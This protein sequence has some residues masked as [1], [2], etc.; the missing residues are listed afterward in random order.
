MVVLLL[1]GEGGGAMPAASR[2]TAELRR[3]EVLASTRSLAGLDASATQ[4]RL[5]EGV[6]FS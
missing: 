2:R 6:L 1:A 5:L 3:L 4:Y